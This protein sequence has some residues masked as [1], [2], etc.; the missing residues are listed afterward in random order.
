M[1]IPKHS[2]CVMLN[3]AIQNDGV[4]EIEWQLKLKTNI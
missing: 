2:S 4:L 1:S 3:C